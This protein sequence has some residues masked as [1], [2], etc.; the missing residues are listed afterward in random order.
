MCVVD[1][2]TIRTHKEED[3]G[4]G[5]VAQSP[6]HGCFRRRGNPARGKWLSEHIMERT[7]GRSRDPGSVL[8]YTGQLLRALWHLSKT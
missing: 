2:Y 4:R 6:E 1:S 8:D 3:T 5:M 7:Y